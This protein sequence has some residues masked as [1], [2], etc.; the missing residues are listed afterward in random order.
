MH[1]TDVNSSVIVWL[2]T[3]KRHVPSVFVIPVIQ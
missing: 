1:T 3:Y 2:L